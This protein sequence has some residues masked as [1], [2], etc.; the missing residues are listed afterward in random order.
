MIKYSA[1]QV[2]HTQFYL[3]ILL[4]SIIAALVFDSTITESGSGNRSGIYSEFSVERAPEG[5]LNNIEGISDF[6]KYYGGF[7]FFIPLKDFKNR[8]DETVSGLYLASYS[9]ADFVDGPNIPMIARQKIGSLTPL[10]G[11]GGRIRGFETR[12]FDSEFKAS[13]NTE[14]RLSLPEIKPLFFPEK[15][16]LRPG[17]LLFFDTGYYDLLKGSDSEAIISCGGGLFGDFS[18]FIK[19]MSYLSFPL[20]GMRL[21]EKALVLSFDVSFHF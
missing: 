8:R 10:N 3:I 21:D 6:T 20:K 5:F 18:G 15:M 13:N 7:S 12:R 4:N 2:N 1:T 9:A 17:A 11:L 14:I 19:G 16:Y